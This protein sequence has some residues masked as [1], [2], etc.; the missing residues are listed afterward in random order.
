MSFSSVLEKEFFEKAVAELEKNM[1]SLS[2]GERTNQNIN[3]ITGDYLRRIEWGLLAEKMKYLEFGNKEDIESNL[4]AVNKSGPPSKRGAI[5]YANQL[6][7]KQEKIIQDN[8]EV[9]YPASTK[10][11][12]K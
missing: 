1:N 8:R 9:F 6:H 11:S 5:L 2:D 4:D 3:R 12:F 7:G 10:V